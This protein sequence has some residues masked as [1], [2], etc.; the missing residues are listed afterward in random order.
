MAEQIGERSAQPAGSAKAPGW[1]LWLWWVL[2]G[3][4]ARP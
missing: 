1:G 4:A 2:A 3:I